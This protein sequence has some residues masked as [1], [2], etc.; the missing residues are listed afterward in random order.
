M[1]PAFA[2][3]G[4]PHWDAGAR[5]AIFGPTRGA[6][7]AELARAALESVCFQTVDPVAAM[8]AGGAAPEGLRIDGGMAR[9]RRFAQRLA[10]LL[11]RFG[12]GSM[13]GL[14]APGGRSPAERFAPRLDADALGRRR[15]EHADGR[16]ASLR[17]IRPLP[18]RWERAERVD[19]RAA[20]AR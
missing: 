3:L 5:G 16:A 19:R 6:G 10:D 11:A 18:E 8:R 15:R 13:D 7:P 20:S 17:L 4:A 2:G 9:N 12:A 14:A 1:V